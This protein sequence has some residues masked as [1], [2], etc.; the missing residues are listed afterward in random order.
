MS[1]RAFARP[2]SITIS[3]GDLTASNGDAQTVFRCSQEDKADVDLA[4]RR[5]HMSSAQFIRMIVIQ[6]ARKILSE[7][8]LVS[9]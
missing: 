8:G 3:L 6:A 4:A 2:A 5:L 9:S 1:Y 7:E